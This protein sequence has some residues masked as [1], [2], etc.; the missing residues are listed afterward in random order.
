LFR[1]SGCDHGTMVWVV[2]LPN[3]IKTWKV[4][5]KSK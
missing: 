1:I 4:F 5:W 3:S 2:Y